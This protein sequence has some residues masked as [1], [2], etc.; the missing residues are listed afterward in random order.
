MKSALLHQDRWP[1]RNVSDST[2]SANITTP[3]SF[4]L[5]LRLFNETF[6]SLPVKSCH[7]LPSASDSDDQLLDGSVEPQRVYDAC[8]IDWSQVSIAQDQQI[9]ANEGAASN[10]SLFSDL[11][12]L[13][14]KHVPN[15]DNYPE[16]LTRTLRK[17]TNLISS[18]ITYFT[19]GEGKLLPEEHGVQEQTNPS[20]DRL[21][22]PNQPEDS[23]SRLTSYFSYTNSGNLAKSTYLSTISLLSMI[24]V[25]INIFII[26]IILLSTK[27]KCHSFLRNSNTGQI[28]LL[29]FQLSVAGLI[30]AGYIVV[31]K[32]RIQG[33]LPIALETA[34]EDLKDHE[35][36]G[37]DFSYYRQDILPDLLTDLLPLEP[38]TNRHS[39][40]IYTIDNEAVADNHKFRRSNAQDETHPAAPTYD[41]EDSSTREL[42]I[43]L[44]FGQSTQVRRGTWYAKFNPP[45][46][47][48]ELI[49]R[50]ELGLY[51]LEEVVVASSSCSQIHADSEYPKQNG[52]GQRGRQK[53][54]LGKIEEEEKVVELESGDF[55]VNI[56]NTSS[57]TI[58]SAYVEPLC[59]SY[60]CTLLPSLI[61]L[62][63]SIYVWTVTAL[64]YD[65][66]CA[67]AHPL[68]YLRPINTLK[69]RTYFIAVWFMSLLFNL[70]L[71][72]TFDQ[73]RPQ[74]VSSS[75]TVDAIVRSNLQEYRQLAGRSFTRL[76]S[77]QTGS[78][79]LCMLEDEP[80]RNTILS[81]EVEQVSPMYGTQWT[82]IASILV[83]LSRKQEVL[84]SSGPNNVS[85]MNSEDQ[86][87]KRA[88]YQNAG[89]PDDV[90]I[91]GELA[92]KDRDTV[93]RLYSSL[94][95]AHSIFSFALSVFIPLVIIT[96]CNISIYRIVKVHE[97]RLSINSGSNGPASGNGSS[98]TL[99]GHSNHRYWNRHYKTTLAKQEVAL[100]PDEK[101]DEDSLVSAVWTKLFRGQ[102]SRSKKPVSTSVSL[103]VVDTGPASKALLSSE[104]QNGSPSLVQSNKSQLKSNLVNRSR[105]L[106]KREDSFQILARLRR[107]GNNESPADLS[108]SEIS[109]SSTQL[110]PPDKETERADIKPRDRLKRKVSDH[111]MTGR[112]SSLNSSSQHLEYKE[113]NELEFQSYDEISMNYSANESR[114]FENGGIFNQLKMAGL[115]FAGIAI[116]ELS[117]AT[118]HRP[119]NKS[120]S[121]SLVNLVQP[122]M[123][124][125]NFSATSES[126]C[127]IESAPTG[128]NPQNRKCFMT[129][130]MSPKS[131]QTYIQRCASK[132]LDY[133]AMED[134]ILNHTQALPSSNMLPTHNRI[135]NFGTKS[136]IF[137]VVT[138][139]T[140]IL[141][142]LILPHY[143]LT[144]IKAIY[145]QEFFNYDFPLESSIHDYNESL[146]KLRGLIMAGSLAKDENFSWSPLIRS[147]SDWLHCACRIL[148]LCVIPLNGWLYG[149]RSRSLRISIR[150]ILKRYISRR[151]ASIEIT[152]RQR[153][154]SSIR[155]RELTFNAHWN[156]QNLEKPSRSLAGA[157]LENSSILQGNE[158]N[159]SGC[160]RSNSCSK[161]RPSTN[162]FQSIIAGSA[163]SNSAPHLQPTM[164]A[165]AEASTQ[166]PQ[167]LD[168][169]GAIRFIID[170]ISGDRDNDNSSGV[171]NHTSQAESLVSSLA[172]SC[173]SL[174]S[175]SAPSGQSMSYQDGNY[176][177]LRLPNKPDVINLTSDQDYSNLKLVQS[178]GAEQERQHR[179]N[180]SGSEQL[181]E[182]N[183]VKPNACTPVGQA[184][185]RKSVSEFKFLITST[186]QEHHVVE[187]DNGYLFNQGV[188]EKQA[189]QNV[190]QLEEPKSGD[191]WCKHLKQ[192][193]LRLLLNAKQAIGFKESHVGQTEKYPKLDGHDFESSR[194]S[195]L[196]SRDVLTL[197]EDDL[198]CST[199][200][201]RTGS[202]NS[203]RRGQRGQVGGGSF[204]GGFSE[205]VHK[206]RRKLRN[207]LS[208]SNLEGLQLEKFTG[209]HKCDFNDSVAQKKKSCSGEQ[210]CICAT[211]HKSESSSNRAPINHLKPPNYLKLIL[212]P[213]AHTY[214]SGQAL[215][216]IK[217]Y[218]SNHSYASSQSSLNNNSTIVTSNETIKTRAK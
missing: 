4:H 25:L 178:S 44:V 24:G 122:T 58:K 57:S 217:E 108:K 106:I 23:L 194:T 6:L 16:F 132:L 203:Q 15:L 192:S 26:F 131:H 210:Y 181:C 28:H 7:R 207:S 99:Q 31:D 82:H 75:C 1:T 19:P 39:D 135:S 124:N 158:R 71:P 133:N 69:S 187:F 21:S 184:N 93:Q 139:F 147:G 155:S 43:L 79:E 95:L 162:S 91:S 63:G 185:L 89:D 30:L 8:V 12:H 51:Q 212:D 163:N 52:Y 142:I 2:G 84:Y 62:T 126:R 175:G 11:D 17:Q 150:M 174:I 41:L 152:Q 67:I 38:Y 120:T 214:S 166:I 94:V 56:S 117:S 160:S 18:L 92:C 157:H 129:V 127:S 188:Q 50:G 164:M 10:G 202:L 167:Q 29:L 96:I 65:R 53:N 3:S 195:S 61:N 100:N 119:L 190:K 110:G 146:K 176:C 40:G 137:N 78:R 145:F 151:Q 159:R 13:V 98:T 138:W 143:M 165:N 121:C 215:S 66:Y 47:W 107:S 88:S 130:S 183:E 216:P 140:L 168:S 169:S 161:T 191:D 27:Q 77:H 46:N 115:S 87:D 136:A 123:G 32:I 193:L 34:S 149:I 116:H 154:I 49:A 141:S 5:L 197:D 114:S 186:D 205:S 102:L 173:R 37:N 48:S 177:N 111:R 64:A 20:I 76:T 101:S 85:L 60:F 80:P 103:P 59:S 170:D 86:T 55:G 74:S 118:H 81:P 134:P 172:S 201:L 83:E 196:C 112:K 70:V 182:G 171:Q 204:K 45:G 206:A 213:D 54:D 22:P 200:L 148:F 90:N 72:M 104:R 68:Q 153:S 208:I 97:R 109:Q 113:K 144:A 9:P 209:D 180:S 179:V 105:R 35:Q 156:S 14:D 211:V 128:S 189:N 125:N 198:Q 199:R 73:F 218:S 42:I 36:L 33:E